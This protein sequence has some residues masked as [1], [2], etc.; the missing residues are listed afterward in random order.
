M[1]LTLLGTLP[2]S[3][4]QL[5]VVAALPGLSGR[6]N[7]A[8]SDL[9]KVQASLAGALSGSATFIPPDPTT[10]A[11][12]LASAIAAQS[13]NLSN[14]VLPT[15]WITGSVSAGAELAVEL[16]TIDAELALVGEIGATLSAGLDV[17]S[18]A[19][20]AWGGPVGAFGT[21]LAATTRGGW[22]KVSPGDPVSGVVIVSTAFADWQHFGASFNV[23]PTARAPASGGGALTFLGELSGGKLNTGTLAAK[24]P[25]DLYRTQLEGAKLAVEASLELT[26]GVNLPS[27]DVLLPGLSINLDDLIGNMLSL[28]LAADL[29]LNIDA[30]SLQLEALQL[31]LGGFEAMVTGGGLTVWKYDGPAGRF[32]ASLEAEIK[33]GIPNAGDGSSIGYGLAIACGSPSAWGGFGLITLL[34]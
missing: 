18:L 34:G 15:T 4:I 17:G 20:W 22:G 21:R 23:G 6:V 14:L 5:G 11:A 2:L 30:L 31:E 10:I 24:Q 19:T 28:D 9:S 27:V 16:G 29:Q 33:D 25:I 7:A 26:L 13:G 32:G 12:T 1:G 8:V 3:A